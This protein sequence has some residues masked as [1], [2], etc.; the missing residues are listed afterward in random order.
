MP[1]AVAAEMSNARAA[2]RSNVFLAATLVAAGKSFSVRVRN[3]SQGGALI[4]GSDLPAAGM[5][6]ILRRGSLR[7][8]AEVAWSELRHCGV[9][10]NT[11][12]RL[13]DWVSRIGHPGQE[14]VDALVRIVRDP[15]LPSERSLVLAPSEDSIS[16][17]SQ[18]LSETCERLANFSQLVDDQAE[19]LIRLDVIAQRLRQLLEAVGNAR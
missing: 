10:F 17:I 15:M 1:Q 18:D 3:I 8:P 13:A 9:R 16:A 6:V 4:D 7:A 19:E 5:E 11:P 14:Q 2:A 12:I